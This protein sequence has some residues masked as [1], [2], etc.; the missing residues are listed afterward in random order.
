MVENAPIAFVSMFLPVVLIFHVFCVQM[1]DFSPLR[2]VDEP[3]PVSLPEEGTKPTSSGSQSACLPARQRWADMA[4]DDPTHP[5]RAPSLVTPA[6]EDNAPVKRVRW[7]DPVEETQPNPKKTHRCA[8]YHH[9]GERPFVHPYDVMRVDSGTGIFDACKTCYEQCC[10]NGVALKPKTWKKLMR[11][12]NAGDTSVRASTADSRRAR[13]APFYFKR[14][15]EIRR[16]ARAHNMS[17]VTLSEWLRMCISAV[18][19]LTSPLPL[20]LSCVLE[21]LRQDSSK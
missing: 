18:H 1:D 5:E 21:Q 15:D 20:V 3:S 13:Y 16:E 4:D 14:G 7:A 9:M 12:Q 8:C 11:R 19:T 10:N 6:D 17:H 2:E